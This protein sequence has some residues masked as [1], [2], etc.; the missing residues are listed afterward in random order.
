MLVPVAEPFVSTASTPRASLVIWPKQALFRVVD[1]DFPHSVKLKFF[2][3]AT[4]CILFI[5]PDCSSLSLLF[6]A[7][8]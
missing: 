6:S 1:S 7:V 4:R 8:R 2:M 3:Q 5:F